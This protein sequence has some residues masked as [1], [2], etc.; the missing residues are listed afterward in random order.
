MKK[1][2][3]FTEEQKQ[4]IKEAFDIHSKDQM[5]NIKN[6]PDAYKVLY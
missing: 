4:V 3:Y 6:I 2:S 5:L 1:E